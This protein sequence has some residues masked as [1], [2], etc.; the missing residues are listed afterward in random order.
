MGGY[1]AGE[2][3]R[4]LAGM[5]GGYLAGMMGEL[6]ISFE[7]PFSVACGS[8]SINVVEAGGPFSRGA[9]NPYNLFIYAR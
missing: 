2:M 6:A 8:F 5:I 3:V 4:Y 7:M 1:L 9:G